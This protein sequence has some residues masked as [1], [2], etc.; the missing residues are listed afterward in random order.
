LYCFFYVDNWP[1]QEAYHHRS[2]GYSPAFIGCLRIHSSSEAHYLNIYF[3][4][5]PP[6]RVCGLL[7]VCFAV[8]SEMF[9]TLQVFWCSWNWFYHWHVCTLWGTYLQTW[10]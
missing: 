9:L 3:R 6:S 2:S 1:P 10:V 4:V 5:L 7:R 8:L